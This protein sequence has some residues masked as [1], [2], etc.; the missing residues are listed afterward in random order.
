MKNLEKIIFLI[1]IYIYIY[2]NHFKYRL[3]Q[4]KFTRASA[5]EFFLRRET[6]RGGPHGPLLGKVGGPGTP[7]LYRQNSTVKRKK[8]SRQSREKKLP[9]GKP[10][11]NLYFLL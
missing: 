4:K 9:G 11:V 5:R 10:T 1:Y 2:T 6:N 8:I 3:T 7:A